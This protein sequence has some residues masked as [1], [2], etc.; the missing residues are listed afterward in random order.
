MSK[1]ARATSFRLLGGAAVLAAAIGASCSAGGGGGTFTGGAG[2]T[3]S[4]AGGNA[5]G[6]SSS[7]TGGDDIGFDAGPVISSSSGGID[8]DAGCAGEA[9]KAQL[10]PLDMF[11]ML[12]KSGS[13]METVSGGGTKWDAITSAL[14]AFFVQPNLQGVS[15]GLQYFGVA[16]TTPCPATCSTNADC[17][18][19]APCLQGFGCL[20]CGVPNVDSCTAADY[21]KADVEISPINQAQINK[22][23]TSLGANPPE[24]GTPT[25]PALQGALDHAKAWAQAHP[26]HAVI[27]VLATDGAPNECGVAAADPANTAAI[28]A[29]L[30]QIAAQGVQSGILTF[31][32]GVFS[33]ADIPKGPTILDQVAAGGGTMKAFNFSTNQSNVNQQFLTALNAIRGTALGCQY[34][35]P[36]SD[37]GM[38]DHNKVNVQ[39][40]PGGTTMIEEFPKYKDAA[41]CPAAGDGWYYDDN[42]NPS[43]ILLCP[44]SCD[45]VSKDTMGQVN[46]VL[47][48]QTKL[49]G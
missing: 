8:P 19:Y 28:G 34:K 2:G 39:Y 45:K 46:I 43:L 1:R 37:G 27:A 36:Q 31:A 5:S 35:I 18:P 23:L 17:G 29:S 10:L 42:A 26:G 30:A 3:I 40:T 49:P 4:G 7:G 41:D 9:T 6:S 38:V 44:P 16:P 11:I 21:A 32:I 15:V 48:C 20:L 47:G 12:D 13:M 14:Q 22:L 24:T 33:P 25:E